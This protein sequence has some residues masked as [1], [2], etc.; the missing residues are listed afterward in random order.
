[1]IL[2]TG[3]TG[4]VGTN[5]LK[6][7]AGTSLKARALARHPE[8]AADLGEKTG[9]EL[10]RADVTDAASLDAAFDGVDAVIHLVGI[11]VEPRGVTFREVH[12]EGTRNVVEACRRNGV[13]RYLH[14]SALGTRAGARSEYHRTKWQAEE[15]VRSSGLDYTILR[16]SVIFGPGD[17]FTNMFAGFV[18][19]FP[20]V[21]IPG[22]G[23]NLF[24]PVFIKNVAGAFVS[25]LDMNE[26]IG[27]VCELG[28][29]ERLTFDDVIEKIARALGRKPPAKVHMPM[30]LMRVGAGLAETVLPTP[31]I[32]RDQLL[33][34]EEDNVTDNNALT[35]VF[36]IEP[37]GFVEGMKTYL[38]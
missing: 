22:S 26:T 33:M 21:V 23:K 18:R 32:T 4:F 35:G 11:L 17:M 36:H 10:V 12:V 25:A 31:P 8:D 20:L 2:V 19:R 3:G 38:H 6:A 9:C 37:T 29:P 28:G 27:K 16:P 24:Q 5:L 30:P 34:L 13:K 7:L 14:M 15:L 1:M